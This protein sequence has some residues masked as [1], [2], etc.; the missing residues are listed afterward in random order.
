MS[1]RFAKDHNEGSTKLLELMKPV[2]IVQ[3]YLSSS[4]RADCFFIPSIF[5]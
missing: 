2:E 3:N 4:L 5:S 1:K